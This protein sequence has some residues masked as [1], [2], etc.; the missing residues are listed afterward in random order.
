MQKTIVLNHNITVTKERAALLRGDVVKFDS[1]TGKSAIYR[2]GDL[3]GTLT[4]VDHLIVEA[5]LHKEWAYEDVPKVDPVVRQPS[6]PTVAEQTAKL[7]SNATERIKEALDRL[8]NPPEP[9]PV[10]TTPF[11]PVETTPLQLLSGTVLESELS[12]GALPPTPTEKPTSKQGK[13]GGRRSRNAAANNLSGDETLP[14]YETE[15]SN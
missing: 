4:T 10:E 15:D 12:F 14:P 5:W 3:V 8:P 9:L 7:P 11:P 1:V 13:R 2:R 6:P